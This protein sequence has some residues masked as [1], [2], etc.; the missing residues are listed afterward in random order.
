MGY[1]TDPEGFLV[2]VR[3][4]ITRLKADDRFADFRDTPGIFR[5]AAVHH[6]KDPEGFLIG[7][8]EAISRLEADDRFADFRD[9]PWIFRRS[10]WQPERPGGFPDQR[11]RDNRAPQ[12][13]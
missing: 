10:Q 12:F 1:P 7:V 6:T 3:E 9:T 11:A 4:A 13:R 2:G 5:D 8:R